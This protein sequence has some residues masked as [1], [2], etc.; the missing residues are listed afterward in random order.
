M[1]EV[2]EMLENKVPVQPG[3]YYFGDPEDILSNK[4]WKNVQEQ[5]TG[6][7]GC[8]SFSIRGYSSMIV[9]VFQPKDP[10]DDDEDNVDVLQCLGV[11]P[12]QLWGK[13]R[14]C[15][16]NVTTVSQTSQLEVFSFKEEES[17]N[18]LFHVKL[19]TNKEKTW[20]AW[21][22]PEMLELMIR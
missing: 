11:V 22:Y 6:H 9:S 19:K 1:S 14:F 20:E 15:N 3:Q 2:K 4:D 8:K 7:S 5:C 10:D 12:C 18:K 16:D 13:K 17:I 21:I